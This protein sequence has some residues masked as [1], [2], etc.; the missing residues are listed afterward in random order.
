VVTRICLVAGSSC[1]RRG[2]KE[3]GS[4]VDELGSAFA[5]PRQQLEL[6][7]VD[8][9]EIWILS[10][11]CLT[12]LLKFIS[13]VAQEVN[14]LLNVNFFSSNVKCFSLLFISPSVHE[15]S[16]RSNLYSGKSTWSTSRREWISRLP[17]LNIWTVRYFLRLLVF[18]L[19]A[20][21]VIDEPY[22]LWPNSSGHGGHLTCCPT[23]QCLLPPVQSRD[24]CHSFTS[25]AVR[26]LPAAPR[27]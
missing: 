25:T 24:Q 20:F 23:N 12:C 5:S 10:Y 3:E 14:I 17:I 26:I 8:Q 19:G 22:F 18:G 6:P 16:T 11:R 15:V 9:F 21:F 2:G 4:S 13:S 27:I 1:G 7:P